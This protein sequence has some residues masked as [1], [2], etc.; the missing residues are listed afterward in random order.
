[1]QADPK[2]QEWYD[3]IKLGNDPESA[4]TCQAAVE[5]ALTMFKGTYGIVAMSDKEEILARIKQIR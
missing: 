4:E 2:G 1:M 3:L 5:R